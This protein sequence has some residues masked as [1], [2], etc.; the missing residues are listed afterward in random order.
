MTEPA[1]SE[2]PVLVLSGTGKTGRRVAARLAALNLAVRIGSRTASPAFDWTNPATWQAALHGVDAVYIAYHPDLAF[3]GAAET[4]ES[5]VSLA[6]RGGVRR[7]VLLSGRGEAGALRAEQAVRD[8]GVDW[9]IVRAS[10]FHQNFSEHFLLEP[11]RHGEIALPASTAREPFVDTD[12]VAAVAVAALTE[13]GH[14]G[15]LYEVTGP[16]LLTF[17][18]AAAEISAATGRDIRFRS[19]GPQEYAAEAAAHGVPAD[20]VAALTELFTTVLDGRNAHL[21]DGVRQALGREPVD[22]ADYARRT[23]ATGVWSPRT[24]AEAAGAHD[25]ASGPAEASTSAPLS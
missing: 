6:V 1:S 4:V 19:V 16:R 12:D 8:A 25:R 21:T 3:P 23:A 20:E 15:L 5:F 13:P 24:A 22:F 10:W 2:R 9:T 7:L 17:A 11:V 14:A 18:D